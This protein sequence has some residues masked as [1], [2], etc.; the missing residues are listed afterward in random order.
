MRALA[1]LAGMAVGGVALVLLDPDRR[2]RPDAPPAPPR[3]ARPPLRAAGPVLMRAATA[4]AGGALA[5]YGHRRR[6]LVGRGAR[7]LGQSML[8]AA[9]SGTA[10]ARWRGTSPATSRGQ[11]VQGTA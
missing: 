2:R 8:G 7:T 5:V 10:F 9:M 3:R 4:V 11:E 6:S 1:L